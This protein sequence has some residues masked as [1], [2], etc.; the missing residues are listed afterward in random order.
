M[1]LKTDCEEEIRD[2]CLFC[3]T[4]I[5]DAWATKAYIRGDGDMETERS[6]T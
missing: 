3:G 1:K 2:F 4:G 6:V 5:D